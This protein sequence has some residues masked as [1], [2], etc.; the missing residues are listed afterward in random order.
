M[1]SCSRERPRL[2]RGERSVIEALQG[3]EVLTLEPRKVMRDA[4]QI[5]AEFKAAN[6]EDE[7]LSW[8]T[9]FLNALE[10]AR[11]DRPEALLAA[12]NIARRARVARNRSWD[13][14]QSRTV[15]P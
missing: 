3:R 5:A 1:A 13:S 7:S 8:D 4:L 11:R 9:E 6:S 14:S 2:T 15:R 12:R 10:E